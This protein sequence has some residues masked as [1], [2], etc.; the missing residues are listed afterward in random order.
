MERA[1]RWDFLFTRHCG[2][3][4]KLGGFLVGVTLRCFAEYIT[5]P[6]SRFVWCVILFPLKSLEQLSQDDSSFVSR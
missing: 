4:W 3:N 5:T 1:V 6:M 2:W